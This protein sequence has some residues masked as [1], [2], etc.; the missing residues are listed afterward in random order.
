M[1]SPKQT[2]SKG[3][4]I[5]LLYQSTTPI[6]ILQ[7]NLFMFYYRI[8]SADKFK[9]HAYCVQLSK[10]HWNTVIQSSLTLCLRIGYLFIYFYHYQILMGF[11]DVLTSVLLLQEKI[12]YRL[13]QLSFSSHIICLCESTLASNLFI[14]CPREQKN[15]RT[16]RN[17]QRSTGRFIL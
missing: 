8:N 15:R 5:I 4:Q 3:L 9:M 16:R 7:Y 12:K 10:M 14:S 6:H 13:S 17:T 11:R 1:K 2:N